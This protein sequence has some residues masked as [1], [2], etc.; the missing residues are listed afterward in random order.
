MRKYNYKSMIPMLVLGM[1]P[2][3]AVAQTPTE[4]SKA[5]FK[6]LDSTLEA[7]RAPGALDETEGQPGH[8]N[9]P[10]PQDG[11]PQQTFTPLVSPI[12]APPAA[13]APTPV[14][15]APLES[16]PT[17]VKGKWN[18]TFYGFLE[19]DAVHDST[20]SYTTACPG[21]ILLARPGTSA[22]DHGR[23]IVDARATRFGFKLAAPESEGMKATA[24]LEMDFFGNQLPTNFGTSSSGLSEGATYTNP[25]LRL[26][27]AAIK[28]E[29]AYIDVLAGQYWQLFGWAP[30]YLPVTAQIPGIPGVSFGR[31][32]QL[33]LSHTFKTAP[34]NVEL[35]V[36]ALRSPHRNSEYPDT[37]GGLRLILNGWTGVAASGATGGAFTEMTA[38]LGVSG[39]YRRLKV[40]EFAAA[41]TTRNS[42]DAGG[43][44][45]DAFL[46]VIRSSLKDKGNSLNLTGNY[47]N[48]KGIADL[49]APGVM[50]GA[51]FP[52]LPNPNAVSP[53]PTWPQD[54]DNGMFTY[55][56][57]G[58]LHP[59]KWVT[60]LVGGQYYLPPSGRV[61]IAGN[62]GYAKSS[63]LANYSLAPEK[64]VTKYIFWDALVF[65][66]VTGPVTVAAEF[67]RTTQTYGDDK[68]AKN[69]RI[70]LSSYYTWY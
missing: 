16:G 60:F 45:I 66:N 39:V 26:R 12:P 33:R 15:P 1:A 42:I 41:P 34:L 69:N 21:Y 70:L 20:Q 43:I 36:A 18:P 64:I 30:L 57:D 29:T 22:G 31:N 10:L 35:A 46:P 5:H 37:Q 56:T 53:A 2:A 11:S 23:T 40:G 47:T 65:V 6:S 48:G 61:W 14:G 4:D 51:T 44:S 52:A 9:T 38:S 67:A 62:F 25:L 27:H 32:V 24:V 28:V 54:I 49:F 55:D 68:Q 63:N 8:V 7:E 13:Q 3:A 17:A 58:V 19:F 59:I 50:G